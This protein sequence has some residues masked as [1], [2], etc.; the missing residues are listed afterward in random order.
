MM[1]LDYLVANNMPNWLP[2]SRILEGGENETFHSF[3]SGEK[4]QL[5]RAQTADH[6]GL[7][8]HIRQE[9]E[10]NK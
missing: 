7:Q 3:L 5:V 9:L 10:G 8:R 6:N 1:V 4:R 2:I